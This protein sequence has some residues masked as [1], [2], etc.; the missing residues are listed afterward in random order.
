MAA[1][2]GKIY[3]IGGEKQDNGVI[4]TVEEFDPDAN[5]GFGAWTT[6]PS[7]MPHP[8]LQ[9]AAAIV[10][11]K[12]YVMGGYTADGG[13]ISTV[14]VYDPALDVWTTDV[15]MPTARRLLGA[16]VVDN[17][18]YAVGGERWSQG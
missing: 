4:D 17:T 1:V 12:V 18:I 11:D 5:G 2:N 16:A 8:R 10:D 6:K 3:A 7:R 13:I 14:D 9:S 15:P